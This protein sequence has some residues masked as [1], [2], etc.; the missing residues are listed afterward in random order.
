MC[1]HPSPSSS[2]ISSI[3]LGRFLLLSGDCS[4]VAGAG[5]GS[6]VEVRVADSASFSP[7]SQPSA[8]GEAELLS[9]TLLF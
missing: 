6:M 5:V 1:Q 3:R 4:F 2:L 9:R 7:V 8:L